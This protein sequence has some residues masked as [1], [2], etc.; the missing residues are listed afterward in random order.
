VG[1]AA[2]T[3]AGLCVDLQG[4]TVLEGRVSLKDS[5]QAVAVVLDS[6]SLYVAG[7]G[8]WRLR[9]FWPTCAHPSAVTAHPSTVSQSIQ[10]D[11]DDAAAALNQIER[12]LLCNIGIARMQ[13]KGR[14]EALL[15]PSAQLALSSAMAL[16][17]TDEDQALRKAIAIA[18][19][20]ASLPGPLARKWLH[21]GRRWVQL[22]MPPLVPDKQA[23]CAS[24]PTVSAYS[25]CR[26]LRLPDPEPALSISMDCAGPALQGEAFPVHI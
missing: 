1:G 9:L 8:D 6:V 26:V 20:A 3:V 10:L 23:G 21:A 15:G 19:P 11:D 14:N 25:R 2:A 12:L 13:G 5:L 16:G 22:P 24:Q 7:G 4:I 18:G 17:T